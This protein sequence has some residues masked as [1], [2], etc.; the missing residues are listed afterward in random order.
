MRLVLVRELGLLQRDRPGDGRGL[1]GEVQ[2]RVLAL[3]VGGPVVVDQ[4]GVGGV[5]LQG[6]EGVAHAA[7]NEDGLAGVELGG[8]DGAEG[9]ALAQVH[10]G[11][12]DPAGGHGDELVPRLGVDAAGGAG[13]F[14]ERDVV[15]HRAEVGQAERHHLFPLPVLLEPAAV[16]AVD[17]K[18]VEDDAGDRGFVRG[19]LLGELDRHDLLALFLVLGFR[20][21]L[22]RPPPVLVVPVPGDGVFDAGLRA[23]PTK[24]ALGCRLG[25]VQGLAGNDRGE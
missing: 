6:L 19:E 1:V 4:V 3:G 2:E 10:P 9:R 7:G 22:L 17:R 16:V 24:A 8:E 18:V 15:L 25:H 11:A 21:G 23:S 5:V 12:E 14:V 13:R 20:G